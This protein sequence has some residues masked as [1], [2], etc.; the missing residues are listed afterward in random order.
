[1][2]ANYGFNATSTT[3]QLQQ[4]FNI[5]PSLH[6]LSAPSP[7]SLLL[8]YQH[9]WCEASLDHTPQGLNGFN[10][11]YSTPIN[12]THHV[13]V[14]TSH[15]PLLTPPHISHCIRYLS[16]CSENTGSSLYS[17]HNNKSM[18]ICFS[19]YIVGPKSFCT[20][21]LWAETRSSQGPECDAYP[22]VPLTRP[23][24]GLSQGPLDL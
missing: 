9:H 22:R 21:S 19:E 11:Q 3:F 2:R 12:H 10:A 24:A 23:L 8:L 4:Y 5:F 14:D 18:E 13:Q 7:Y 20:S 1:M 6:L 16:G 17:T 15:A